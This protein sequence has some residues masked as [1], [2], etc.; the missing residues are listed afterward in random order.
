MARKTHPVSVEVLNLLFE[1]EIDEASDRI[2]DPLFKEAIVEVSHSLFYIKFM[3]R[4]AYK[5]NFE[6]SK[7]YS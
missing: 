5:C 3:K 6:L 1:E 7:S 2:F 4:D